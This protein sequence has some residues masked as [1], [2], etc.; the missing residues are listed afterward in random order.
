M[1]NKE[2]GRNG[3]ETRY[4]SGK[5]AAKAG[6]KGGSASGVVRQQRALFR[7]SFKERMTP[8][9][10]AKIF[11]ALAEK[12]EAG[13]VQAAAFLRDTMGEKPTDK[14]EQTVNEITFKGEGI[15]AEEADELFG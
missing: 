6:K 4:R 12:A 10:M 13:D 1:A 3:T 9:R 7:D 14:I 2:A 15:S 11:D 8:E 5:E